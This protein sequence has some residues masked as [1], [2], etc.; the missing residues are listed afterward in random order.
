MP[1]LQLNYVVSITNLVSQSWLAPRAPISYVI[2]ARSRG[3]SITG[4]QIQL[5]VIKHIC[6]LG[7][8]LEPACNWGQCRESS[9]ANN[10]LFSIIFPFISLNWKPVPVQYR[11]YE[12]ALVTC[13]WPLCHSRVNYLRLNGFLVKVSLMFV[14]RMENTT[15]LSLKRSS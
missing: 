6:I 13:N 11:E 7:V 15:E 12:C 1:L 10:N 2:G 5:L 4:I 14:K 3:C 8:G 9:N